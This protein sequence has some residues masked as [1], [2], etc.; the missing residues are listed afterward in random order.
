MPKRSPSPRLLLPCFTLLL[1]GLLTAC[2]TPKGVTTAPVPERHAP[3]IP[4]KD[5]APLGSI[6]VNAIPD[7]VPR[8]EPRSRYGNPPFYI[9]DGIRYD[10]LPTVGGYAERG[11]ASWYGTK[12]HGRRT[13]SGEPYD[14]YQ[15]TAAHKTLPIP[16][17]ARVTNLRTGRSIIVRINDRG[18]FKDNRIIDL[19]YAA[20]AKLGILPEGTGLVEVRTI[21]PAQPDY[22][23]TIAAA[24]PP[25]PPAQTSIYLQIGAFSNQQNAER[26]RTRLQGADFPSARITEAHA[27]N[28]ARVYRVRIGPIASVEDADRMVAKLIELGINDSRV[29]VD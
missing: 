29:V 2:S 3:G 5:G 16:A 6:D 20:A 8:V 12:F 24:P 19:S 1:L 22:Q 11:I 10:V 25:P 13:S 4:G 26:L 15:M 28:S 14:L 18:P 21:D 23:T 9:Q 27:N 7:P 17:Y